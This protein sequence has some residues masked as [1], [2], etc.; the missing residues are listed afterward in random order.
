MAGQA[1]RTIVTKV[2]FAAVDQN[3]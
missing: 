3:T 2:V 1:G